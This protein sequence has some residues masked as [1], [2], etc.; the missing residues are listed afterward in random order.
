MTI[1]TRTRAW[2]L[3]P[4]LAFGVGL[5]LSASAQA[6]VEVAPAADPAAAKA[7]E[8]V[9]GVESEEP[10]AHTVRVEVKLPD[11]VIQAEFPRVDG[12]RS[13]GTT[14]PLSPPLDVDGTVTTSR[15][16]TVTWTGDLA[17]G[18]RAQLRLRVRVRQ[19][20]PVEGL[21]FPAVQRYSDGTVVRWIGPPGSDTPAAV[22]AGSVP[23]VAVTA[24][25]AAPS[26]PQVSP[27]PSP[28]TTTS[29]ETLP[30]DD[31]VVV[32]TVA[33]IGGVLAV[34]AA[35]A[36]WLRRRRRAKRD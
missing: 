12:W 10:S 35:L 34:F 31:D 3:T 5:A 22:L 24:A 19:G 11:N 2:L 4:L 17:P 1:H 36:V 21:V 32:W 29:T 25:T 14:E 8:V 30:A 23:T 13:T 7:G 27:G 6:H 20:T 16:T 26:R 28:S 9:I 15:I 18:K 33:T